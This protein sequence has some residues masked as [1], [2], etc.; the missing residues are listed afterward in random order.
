MT[1]GK[2]IL[3]A[4]NQSA[5]AAAAVT[6]ALPLLMRAE[7]VVVVSA[8]R[9]NRLGPTSAHVARYLAHWGVTV[10]CKRTQGRQVER[11]ILRTCRAVE[12][13]LLVMGAYSRSRLRQLVLGGVT[14]HMLFKSD[15]PVFLLHR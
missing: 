6:A 1:G 4:W 15:L 10:E 14:E 2:R 3:V 13:D 5:D 11:E 7:R 8:G 12:S 9:E